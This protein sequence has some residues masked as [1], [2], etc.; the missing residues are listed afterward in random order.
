VEFDKYASQPAVCR[1]VMLASPDS[2]SA[3]IRE[4]RI[5]VTINYSINSA[6]SVNVAGQNITKMLKNDADK[7]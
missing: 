6:L 4:L 2:D 7:C 3:V 1:H 5:N